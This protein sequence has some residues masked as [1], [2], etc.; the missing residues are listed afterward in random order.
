MKVANSVLVTSGS[1]QYASVYGLICIEVVMDQQG[2][3]WQEPLYF[4][5]GSCLAFGTCKSLKGA[6]QVKIRIVNSLDAT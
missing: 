1:S 5:W 6:L 4:V 3:P 2:A